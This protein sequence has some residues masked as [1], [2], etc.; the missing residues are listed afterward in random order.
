[1]PLQLSASEKAGID[2]LETQLETAYLSG[3]EQPPG[4][5]IIDKMDSYDQPMIVQGVDKTAELK[6][7]V[8][9][10]FKSL[11]AAMLKAMW[12]SWTAVT[13]MNS[14]R[15][16]PDGNHAQ[17]QYRISLLGTVR[18]RGLFSA[19]TNPRTVM[20]NLPAGYRPTTILMFPVV[21]NDTLGVIEIN[22]N[23]DVYCRTGPAGNAPTSDT[24]WYSLSNISFEAEQ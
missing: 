15:Q 6:P 24:A 14:W 7:K 16:W 10:P 9:G 17:C 23:G 3:V 4:T 12:P 18:I 22:P 19:P 20:F 5:A 21:V 11:V 13:F 2:R 8:K 1:M